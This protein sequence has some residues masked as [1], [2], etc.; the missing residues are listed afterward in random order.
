[1]TSW[2]NFP[3]E[4]LCDLFDR[5]PPAAALP[6][7]ITEIRDPFINV[8]KQQLKGMD[9]AAQLTNELPGTW[10][11]LLF[12][13][14]WTFNF[15]DK[16]ALFDETEEDLSGR[17]GHP[18]TVGNF[19]ITLNKDQWSFFY[20]LNYVGETDN[21]ASFGQTTVTNSGD[22]Q[23]GIDLTADSVV[24]HSLSASRQ[25]GD[26]WLARVGVANLSDEA[27][28]R[29]TSLGTANEV[30]VVGAAAFYSQYDWLGRRF[31]LNVTK[32]F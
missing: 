5:D 10:G 3:N 6:N 15:E 13:T 25:F 27:P 7:A 21:T 17:A 23:V 4:P 16:V 14:Q 29:L 31:F 20:G 12:D 9:V 19:N 2:S 26:G 22:E 30:D 32:Q 8:A 18:E 28:P 11:S 24:Y 1:L